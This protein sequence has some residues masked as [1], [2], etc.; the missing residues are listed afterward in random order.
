MNNETALL[1]SDLLTA[2]L[3][4]RSLF[5]FLKE[6]WDVCNTTEYVHNWHIEYICDEVQ[7]VADKWILNRPYHIKKDKWYQGILEDVALNLIINIPP[8]TTKSTIISRFL[9]AW[10]W[11]IDDSKSIMGAT[12]DDKNA[13]EFATTSRDIIQSDKFKRY[14]PDVEIRKDVSAKTFYQSESGGKRY[15]LTTRGKSKTGKHV[16]III[17]DDPMDYITAQSPQEAKQCIEGFK[18]LQTRKKD[19]ATNPYILVMQRL[20]SIDTTAHALKSFDSVRHICLPAEDIYDNIQPADLRNHYVDDLL[21]PVRLSK[22]VL[23]GQRRGLNDDSM[24]I[25]E[26]AYNI[27]FNQV[28]QITQGLLYPN[29]NMV[30]S[31]PENRDGAVRYSFTDVADTGADYFATWFVEVNSGKIFIYD[32][33][34]TQEGSGTTSKKLKGKI[35]LH[36]SIVNKLEVNNQGSVFISSMRNMGVNVS[37]Y[38]SSGNKQERMSAWADFVP[39]ISF[40]K[41]NTQPYHT[42]EYTAALKHV[43]AYPK[44]GKSADGHDDAEDALTEVVRYLYTNLRYLFGIQN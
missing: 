21:D 43:E 12:I 1:N 28:S 11:A 26:I 40:V 29:L 13:T 20:S 15:S 41:P 7:L 22:E 3:C 30:D 35:G 5:L 25:S 38:H 4:K 33:I 14:F 27:Q 24:P 34:Y 31:L 10:I 42:N 44:Q 9:P 37:G 19:K 18:A 2:E 8:G 16:D 32:A 6:F 39:Y 17:D 23:Q 36:N